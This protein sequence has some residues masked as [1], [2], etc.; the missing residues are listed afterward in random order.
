MLPGLCS[1]HL[2]KATYHEKHHNSAP[3]LRIDGAAPSYQFAATVT[4]WRQCPAGSLISTASLNLI[5]GCSSIPKL[6]AEAHHKP[7]VCL[8]ELAKAAGAVP[9]LS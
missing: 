6:G 8:R 9:S 2:S 5:H 1:D 4:M 7:V 3:I